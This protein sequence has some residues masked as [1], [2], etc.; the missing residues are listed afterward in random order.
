MS[1]L[2]RK[3]DWDPSQLRLAGDKAASLQSSHR[4][5]RVPVKGAFLAGPIDVQW[6]CQAR[7]L[8][9]TALWAGLALWYLRGLRKS[10]KF[11]VSN[12]MM[13]SWSVEP[14]AKRRALRKLQK[15]GLIEIESRERRS[16][17]VTLILEA[18][19]K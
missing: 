17:V 8:G 4:H 3:Q 16:P 7:K 11:V 18:E 6:L 1:N 13:A 9:V 5:H 10:D 14:D 19:K 12:L 2:Y 15:A